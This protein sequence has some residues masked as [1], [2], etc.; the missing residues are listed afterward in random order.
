ME[1]KSES[2]E[3]NLFPLFLFVFGVCVGLFFFFILL[4][5]LVAEVVSKSEVISEGRS[6]GH[7]S[8]EIGLIEK[9]IL[10]Y[11]FPC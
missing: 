2:T 8:L 6:V 5:G 9:S 11:C 10:K 7:T 4:Q 3:W 1:K